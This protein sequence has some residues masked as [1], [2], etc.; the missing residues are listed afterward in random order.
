VANRASAP[1]TRRWM[2][3]DVMASVLTRPATLV[4][5]LLATYDCLPASEE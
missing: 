4:A 2:V 5:E 3:M 1:A